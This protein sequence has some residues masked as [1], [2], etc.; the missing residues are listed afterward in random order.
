MERLRAGDPLD[1]CHRPALDLNAENQAGV[2]QA[3]VEE[4]IASA[5][6]AVIAP[7][8]AAGETQLVPEDLEEALPRLAEELGL[9]AVDGRQDVDLSGHCQFSLARAASL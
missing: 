1:A 6:I 2:D 7:F 8:L 3:A 9:L 5:A 4:D